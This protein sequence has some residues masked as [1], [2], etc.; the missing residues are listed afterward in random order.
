M[1]NTLAEEARA[2]GVSISTLKRM[3]KEAKEKRTD[4]LLRC[5]Q[6]LDSKGNL[7]EDKDRTE[8]YLKEIRRKNKPRRKT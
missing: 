6:I 1:F 7:V 4:E 8:Q 3:K 2:K 5:G